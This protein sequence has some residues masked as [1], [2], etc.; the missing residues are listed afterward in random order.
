MK[1][2]GESRVILGMSIARS[3]ES[4]TLTITQERYA[5]KIIDSFGMGSARGQSTPMDPSV[6]LSVDTELC[7]EPYREAIGSIMYFM[8]CTLPDLVVSVCNLAKFVEKPTAVEHWAAVKRMLSYV[9][10][11]RNL[12]LSCA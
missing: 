4:R 9:I 3:H 6:D 10:A 1:H 11:S 2:L 12:G 8:V 5:Q 7:T